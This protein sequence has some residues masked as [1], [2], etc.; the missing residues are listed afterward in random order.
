VSLFKIQ[1]RKIQIACD[2]ALSYASKV[3]QDVMREEIEKIVKKSFIF[4][5]WQCTPIIRPSFGEAR[6]AIL[7]SDDWDFRRKTYEARITEDKAH[8][9]LRA[10]HLSFSEASELDTEDMNFV[11]KFHKEEQS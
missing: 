8:S 4:V 9:L 10:I 2:N 1:N 3:K 5:S 11:D 6:R 7:E